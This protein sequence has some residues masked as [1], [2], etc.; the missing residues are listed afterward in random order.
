MIGRSDPGARSVARWSTSLGSTRCLASTRIDAATDPGPLTRRM[1]SPDGGRVEGGRAVTRHPPGSVSA[2]RRT[3]ES[4]SVLPELGVLP[5]VDNSLFLA[6]H[7]VKEAYGERPPRGWL[8][9]LSLRSA[10]G[11]S[12]AT[13]VAGAFEQG[14]HPWHFL[15]E[16]NPAFA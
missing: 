10:T 3:T 9:S 11:S 15:S 14:L 6:T 7:R 1:A 8:S 16:E 12:T 5:T 2:S 13:R 4:V